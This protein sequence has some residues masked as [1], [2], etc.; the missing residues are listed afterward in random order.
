MKY[1]ITFTKAVVVE[2]PDMREAV[3][4]VRKRYPKYKGKGSLLDIKE[5]REGE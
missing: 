4:R 5:I 1:Q 2:A 3:K